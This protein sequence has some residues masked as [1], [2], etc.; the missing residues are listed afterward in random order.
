[1]A[2]TDKPLSEVER[3]FIRHALGLTM[4]NRAYRNH[5]AAGGDDQIA[6]GRALVARGY[7]VE[8]ARMSTDPYFY[9]FITLAGF[10]AVRQPWEELDREERIRMEF[11]E[12][13][14]CASRESGAS[15]DTAKS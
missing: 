5:Y 9:F 13:R 14:K 8:R 4:T 12:Q 3:H 7:A 2:Q 6:I 15:A 10:E 11:R 1:V